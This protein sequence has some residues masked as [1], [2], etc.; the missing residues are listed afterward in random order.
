MELPLFGFRVVFSVP[1][2]SVNGQDIGVV[3]VAD[4]PDC[5]KKQNGVRGRWY[6]GATIRE[7]VA[8]DRSR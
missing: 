1:R 5:Q 7:V 2:S 8:W 3:G 4:C 6:T